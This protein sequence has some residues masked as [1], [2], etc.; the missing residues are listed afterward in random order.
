MKRYLLIFAFFAGLIPNMKEMTVESVYCVMG[1]GMYDEGEVSPFS[2]CNIC[3]ENLVTV[4]YGLEAVTYCPICQFYCK[5]CKEVIYEGQKDT[6]TCEAEDEDEDSDGS[7][8]EQTVLYQCLICLY[9]TYDET[10]IEEHR[11]LYNHYRIAT[12]FP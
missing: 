11:K 10:Q 1:Q 3:N 4:G 9:Y 5:K 6:H 12:R 7:S 2:T 8:N